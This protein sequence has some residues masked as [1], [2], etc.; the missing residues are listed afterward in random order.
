M[1]DRHNWYNEVCLTLINN[2]III[3]VNKLVKQRQAYSYYFHN[4]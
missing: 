1:I 3:Y 2:D 4:E